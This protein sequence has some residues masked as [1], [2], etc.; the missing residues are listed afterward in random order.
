L[1]LKKQIVRENHWF[2][3]FH[4]SASLHLVTNLLF[5]ANSGMIVVLK[6]DA[7]KSV[8]DTVEEY[9]TVREMQLMDFSRG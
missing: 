2:S 7:M 5:K 4:T 6:G 9:G 8:G 3:L 1:N